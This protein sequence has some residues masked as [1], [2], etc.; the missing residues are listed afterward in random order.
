MVKKIDM[1]KLDKVISVQCDLFS[2]GIN[3]YAG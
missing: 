3:T 1:G 2:I